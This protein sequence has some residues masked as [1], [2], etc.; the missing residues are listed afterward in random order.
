M[1]PVRVHSRPGQ[2]LI[3][4]LIVVLATLLLWSASRALA[5][6]QLRVQQTFDLRNLQQFLDRLDY[7]GE[8]SI[9]PVSVR[10]DELNDQLTGKQLLGLRQERLAYLV[11]AEGTLMA[12]IVPATA[13]DGFNGFVDLLVAVDMTGYLLAARVVR[14]LSRGELHG[15]VDVIDSRWMAGFDGNTL[16]D[17]RRISWQGI[18]GE[19]EYDQFVG[20]S[21]TPRA[22]TD[23]LYD[24]LVFSLSNR[25]VF[26]ALIEPPGS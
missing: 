17:V 23:R 7:H 5:D 18:C 26:M 13:E 6:R 3:A 21:L 22:V 12:S 4:L 9:L 24:A 8:L 10:P 19:G 25:M 1:I 14:D 20:A 16:R 11:S 15:V 2:A